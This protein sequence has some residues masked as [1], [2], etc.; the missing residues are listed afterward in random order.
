M[1]V[2]P[3][4]GKPAPPSSIVNVPRLVTAYFAERPDPHER[5]ERAL[6]STTPAIA[7]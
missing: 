4:A 1:A 2:H 3:L 7:A 5:S 6:C